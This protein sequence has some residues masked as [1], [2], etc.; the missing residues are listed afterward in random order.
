[1]QRVRKARRRLRLQP[2]AADAKETQAYQSQRS[3]R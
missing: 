3:Y 1:M 2:R